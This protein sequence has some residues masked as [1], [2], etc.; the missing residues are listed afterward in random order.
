MKELQ[1]PQNHVSGQLAVAQ[2]DTSC[3]SDFTKIAESWPQLSD[4]I[5]AGIIAMVKACIGDNEQQS[6]SSKKEE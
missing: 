4:V 3:I 6:A 2:D 1:D 5:K